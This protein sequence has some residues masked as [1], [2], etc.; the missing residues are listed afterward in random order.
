VVNVNTRKKDPGNMRR[1]FNRM[2]VLTVVMW[3]TVCF[4]SMLYFARDSKRHIEQIAHETARESIEKD[5]LYRYW[6]A[7]HGGIY[8]PVTK[9]TPP[10]PYLASVK[11]RDITTS[12]G[13]RLTLMHPATMMRQVHELGRDFSNIQGHYTSLK[14]LQPENAPDAWEAKALKA[15]E[16]GAKEFGEVVDVQGTAHYRLMYPLVIVR[17]CLTCHEA[18]GYK[19]GDLRGGIGASIPMDIF[20]PFSWNHLASEAKLF[21]GLWVL[22]LV[23]VSLV[24]PFVRRRIEEQEKAEETLRRNWEFTQ[25]IIENEPEC[26]KI[27]GPGGE[28]KSMNPAGLAM[29]DAD[30]IDAVLGKPVQQL[31]V[32]DHREAF[33]R[34]TERVFAGEGGSLEFEMVGLKGTRRWLETHAVPLRG[35]AGEVESLLGITR[36]VTERKQ[37]ELE[38]QRSAAR[39]R[40]LFDDNPH[41]MWVYDKASLAFLTVNDVAVNKYGYSLEEFRAMTIADIRPPE[42]VPRLREATERRREGVLTTGPW[43]HR[44]RDGTLID[45]E[46]TSHTMTWEGRDAVLVLAND[47]TEHKRAEHELINALNLNRTLIDSLPYPSVLIRY[48]GRTILAANRLARENGAEIGR[49]C[50]EGFGLDFDAALARDACASCRADEMFARGEIVVTQELFAKERWWTVYWIPVDTATYLHFS[51]DITERK[52]LEHQLLQTQKIESVGRL[53][54][55]IAHDINNM[56][57]PIL[58]YAEMLETKIPDGDDRR[59]DL[60]EITGAANRVKDMT[61]QLLAFAR[62][63]TL[64][65]RPLDVNVVISRFG[66]MLQRTLRENILIKLSLAPS[67]G[68]VLADERQL[69]QVIL[70]LAVNAQD[71]MPQ[72]GVLMI[73]TRDVVLDGSFVETRPGSSPGRHLLIR[74]SDTGMGMDGE[75][76]A[77]LFEPFFTTKESGR[78]TGLGLA[79]VYGI[80]KQHKGFVDVQSEPR[81]GATFSLYLPVTEDAVESEAR[82]EQGILQQGS[83]TILVVEDQEQVLRL[84]SLML[85]RSGYHVLT[86][87]SGREALRTAESYAGEIHL[88]V[89][90]VIMPDMN[91]KELFEQLSEVRQGFAIL[92]M[93]GYPADVISTHG[94]LD[95][96]INFL[97]KPFSVHELTA[98]VRQLLDSRHR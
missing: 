8:V 18:Q 10:N 79:T 71:A 40:Q 92:Y 84:V 37:A 52:K 15:L 44:K 20:K 72:G 82:P 73:S 46:I 7:Q 50:F 85:T 87:L 94:A 80:I 35:R 17:P 22:G 97:R 53:A 38:L 11:D 88:V 29:I 78:G 90:D 30:S 93:S 28:V 81:Q 51:I 62:K 54:G 89:S 76:L 1:T 13:R 58:G 66:K 12:S 86:A 75:T 5:M 98:K 83:E 70:N 4:G 3:T 25:S 27:L 57:T 41:P 43:R 21:G 49:L 31:V 32:P 96:G 6:A 69:E 24:S 42:D 47:V 63:Q 45:V 91:G 64:D 56:L 14:P 23:G 65:V 61:Q 60:A 39:Y 2:L 67:I 26:V 36:D 34:L 74:V 9:S 59:E 19:L 48:P 33:I 68:T 55:G 95:S 16:G 77:R